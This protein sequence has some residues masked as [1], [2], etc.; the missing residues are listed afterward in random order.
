VTTAGAIRSSGG[1]V[2]WAPEVSRH[3]TVNQQHVNVTEAGPTLFADL[4]PN[5]VPR[6]QRID[7][8]KK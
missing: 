7:G 8:D 5:P 2:E 1:I 6:G 3:G 4:G